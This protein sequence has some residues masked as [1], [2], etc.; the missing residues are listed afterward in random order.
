MSDEAGPEFVPGVL[1]DHSLVIILAV[2]ERNNGSRPCT[3]CGRPPSKLHR[4]GCPDSTRARGPWAPWC[5]WD[6]PSPR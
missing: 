5:D 4:L 6:A 3:S 2:F 1:E